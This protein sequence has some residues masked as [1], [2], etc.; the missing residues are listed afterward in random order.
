MSR[1][2]EQR[3]KLLICARQKLQAQLVFYDVAKKYNPSDTTDEQGIYTQR[4][5]CLVDGV[6]GLLLLVSEEERFILETHLIKGSKWEATILEYHKRWPFDAGTEQHTFI[7]R[8]RTAIRKMR[9]YIERYEQ[10]IDFSWLDDP[11]IDGSDVKKHT[12]F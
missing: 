12:R 9:Y 6:D 3:I 10:Y 1:N 5:R 4:L 7:N 8:Q 11:M 2:L